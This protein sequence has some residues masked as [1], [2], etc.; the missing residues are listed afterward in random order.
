M[1]KESTGAC[2]HGDLFIRGGR[3]RPIRNFVILTGVGLIE[4]ILL[5]LGLSADAFAVAIAAGVAARGGR[6]PVLRIAAAFG[7]AQGVM[8]LLGY[9]ASLIAGSWFTTIDHWVAFALLGFLGVQMIRAGLD[10]EGE[11]ASFETRSFMGLLVAA[12]ATSIDAAAAGLTLP[13]LATPIWT[14]CAI[15]AAV[16][17]LTSGAGAAFGGRLGMA[18]GTRAEVAGGLVLIGIGARILAAHLLG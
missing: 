5:A 12:I 18:F 10:G 1:K 17:A 14:S 4:L 8:P 15:I 3:A 16:T 11:A 6:P 2:P 9:A 7:I 13:L